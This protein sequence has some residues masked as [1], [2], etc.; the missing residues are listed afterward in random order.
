LESPPKDDDQCIERMANRPRAAEKMEKDSADDNT[1]LLD[2]KRDSVGVQS[3]ED[4][5]PVPDT[6]A[7]EQGNNGGGQA[8]DGCLEQR[9]G[10]DSGY[11]EIGRKLKG[12]VDP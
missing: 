3:G 2:E 9:I 1:G 8:V 12:P 11:Q 4:V 10:V 5:D 6:V 7:E